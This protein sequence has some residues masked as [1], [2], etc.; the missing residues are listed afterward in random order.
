MET[1]IKVS[2][3]ADWCSFSFFY[4][5]PSIS[6]VSVDHW[7]NV[8]PSCRPRGAPLEGFCFGRVDS[9]LQGHSIIVL[10]AVDWDPY[11]VSVWSWLCKF[12]F[13]LVMMKPS[14]KVRGLLSIIVPV[15]Q[16]D[17]SDRT[18]KQGMKQI[19]CCRRKS[20]LKSKHSDLMEKF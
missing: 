13:W 19:L 7:C 16:V 17:P 9:E 4:P 12:H 8:R 5:N 20:F 15:S 1:Q 6:A 3:R 18:E 14:F 11:F 2:L 10:D